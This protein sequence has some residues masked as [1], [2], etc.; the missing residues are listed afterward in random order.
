MYL[1]STLQKIELHVFAG[2]DSLRKIYY[3]GTKHQWREMYKTTTSNEPLFKSTINCTDGDL[4]YHIN[5]Y[6]D[7]KYY[8]NSHGN[9]VVEEN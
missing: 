3:N 9:Y 1:P 8:I 2:C 5:S 4:K 7:L 6:D